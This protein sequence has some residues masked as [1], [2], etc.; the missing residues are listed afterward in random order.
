MKKEDISTFY[1]SIQTEIDSAEKS[2]GIKKDKIFDIEW[3]GAY[4]K[5]GIFVY[6]L[7]RLDFN[8]NFWLPFWRYEIL[9]SLENIFPTGTLDRPAC[10]IFIVGVPHFNPKDDDIIYYTTPFWIQK[11]IDNFEIFEGKIIISKMNDTVIA[12]RWIKFLEIMD[13]LKNKLFNE[14]ET[15]YEYFPFD[16]GNP[17]YFHTGELVCKQCEAILSNKSQ[18]KEHKSKT[19]HKIH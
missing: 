19:G 7:K 5:Y 9:S 8:G 1:K 11:H 14:I 6:E 18:V 10:Q 16:M 13:K 2:H 15:A 4:G 12:K 3:A 17:T